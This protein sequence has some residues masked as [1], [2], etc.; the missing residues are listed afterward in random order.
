MLMLN[1]E[2][3]Q[4]LD[5]ATWHAHLEVCAGSN[6]DAMCGSCSAALNTEL[7]RDEL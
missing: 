6:V 5:S 1:T 7:G 2:L 4:R 3:Q